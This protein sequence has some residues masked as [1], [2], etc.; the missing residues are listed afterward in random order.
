MKKLT[1]TLTDDEYA[2]AQLRC[3]YLENIK[4][5]RYLRDL[6][7]YDGL[8]GG[9]HSV[10]EAHRGMSLDKQDEFTAAVLR[11]ASNSEGN[12]SQK[13]WKLLN[14][15]LSEPLDCHR[16]K[17]ARKVVLEMLSSSEAVIS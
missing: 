10:S 2:L 1:L 6:V 4:M 8:A 14:K 7:V 12:G 17:A 11:Q 13:F 3:A 5:N 15:V 16:Q 9:E